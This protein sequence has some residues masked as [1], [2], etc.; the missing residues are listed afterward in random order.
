MPIWDKCFVIGRLTITGIPFPHERIEIDNNMVLKRCKGELGWCE[1]HIRVETK[2]GEELFA[3]ESIRAAQKRILDFVSIYTLTTYHEPTFKEA[4]ASMM[5]ESDHLGDAICGFARATVTYPEEEKK[6]H[7]ERES[8]LLAEVIRYFKSNEKILIDNSWL[9]NALRYFYFAATSDRL[10][11]RL[12]NMV[13]S[14]ESLFFGREDR[15]E[16][17]Y[18]LSFR[19]AALIGNLFD[20]KTTADV[21]DEI[22]ELYDKRCDVVHGRVT[23]V[24]QDDVSKLKTY[25]RRAIK[26]FVLMLHTESKEK[27]LKMLDHCLVEKESADKLREICGKN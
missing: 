20:D 16:L 22:K 6:K 24:T 12:I 17:R 21:F 5:K 2:E 14:L 15:G 4:G 25:T 3:S 11:D 18:R 19:A 1:A 26:A 8:G 13:V 23:K 27:I 9:R 7:I 10:E